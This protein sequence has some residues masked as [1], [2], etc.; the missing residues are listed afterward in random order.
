[1]ASYTMYNEAGAPRKGK[2]VGELSWFDVAPSR[3]G[4]ISELRD[5]IKSEGIKEP[6]HVGLSEGILHHGHHRALIARELN[7][8]RIP[9]TEV[10]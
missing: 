6:L 10:E 1:M 2:T 4:Y 7:L 5:S 8:P 9:V 3:E